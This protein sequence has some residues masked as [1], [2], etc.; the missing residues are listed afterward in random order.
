MNTLIISDSILGSLATCRIPQISPLTS[1]V[2][3]RGCTIYSTSHKYQE[4]LH[5]PVTKILEEN[6]HFLENIVFHLGTNDISN[7]ASFQDIC[8][9]FDVVIREVLKQVPTTCIFLS[10]ILPR[11]TNRHTLQLNEII[12]SINLRLK[13]YCAQKGITFINHPQFESATHTS[14]YWRG[15]NDTIHPSLEGAQI[16]ATNILR[17]IDT[18]AE[19]RNPFLKPSIGILEYS[20]FSRDDVDI[21]HPSV[22]SFQGHAD[23]FSN[24]YVC[25]LSLHDGVF[26]SSEHAYQFRKAKHFH[27]EDLAE[28][29]RS[30]PTAARAKQLAKNIKTSEEWDRAKLDIMRSVLYAKFCQ[31]EA[32]RLALLASSKKIIVEA[33]QGD[34]YW[35][36]GLSKEQ[37]KTTTHHLWPGRNMMGLLHMQLR[38]QAKAEV[39]TTRPGPSCVF[40]D[41]PITVLKSQNSKRHFF[42]WHMPKF[43]CHNSKDLKAWEF[44]FHHL[45][46]VL[47]VTSLTD[48]ARL[49]VSKNWSPSPKCRQ[50]PVS[51]HDLVRAFAKQLSLPPPP[52]G[53]YE[54]F[55]PCT[56][57]VLINWKVIAAVFKYG[58]DQPDRD[59]MQ[60]LVMP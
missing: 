53:M 52:N 51:D 8:R 7:G 35:S 4:R 42:T 56:P 14:A 26:P 38:S 15:G 57:A 55:P 13:Q 36:S 30:A 49:I 17:S 12:K 46:S 37:I 9:S 54:C 11:R 60:R 39:S 58:L 18:Q 48:L 16:L 28:H 5:K 10:A 45:Q 29:I 25:H 40:L 32:Y 47:N 19:I 27:M 41:C 23:I 21:D 20:S 43:L 1:L 31:V 22:E 24:F 59:F 50:V 44:F 2:V 33:V 6:R 34:F 3:G